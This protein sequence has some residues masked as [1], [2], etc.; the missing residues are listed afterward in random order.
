VTF[1]PYVLKLFT[2]VILFPTVG[3]EDETFYDLDTYGA[4][5]IKLF[6]AVNLYHSRQGRRD[7]L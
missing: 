5:L 2:V 1:G 7:I 3:E 4:D 6:T